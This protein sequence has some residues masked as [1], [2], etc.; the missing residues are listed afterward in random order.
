MSGQQRQRER[1]GWRR[2]AEGT[3]ERKFDA[4]TRLAENTETGREE[5]MGQ[6]FG[7]SADRLAFEKQQGAVGRPAG[8]RQHS[9]V[10]NQDQKATL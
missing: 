4:A 1:G 6:R 9:A 8:A 2:A 7:C 5:G 3:G 10:F